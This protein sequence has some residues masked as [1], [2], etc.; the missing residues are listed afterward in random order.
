MHLAGLAS[1]AFIL[2]RLNKKWIIWKSWQLCGGSF[3]GSIAAGLN[4]GPN[5]GEKRN[6]KNP[7]QQ[8][9]SRNSRALK[10]SSG[11]GPCPSSRGAARPRGRWSPPCCP[12]GGSRFA[13]LAAAPPSGDPPGRPRAGAGS[14]GS[15]PRSRPPR[16]RAAA[17]RNR[18]IPRA[19]R[20]AARWARRPGRLHSGSLRPGGVPGSGRCRSFLPPGPRHAHEQVSGKM[21]ARAE[22]RMNTRDDPRS[23][24]RYLITADKASTPGWC[25][26]R[27]TG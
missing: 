17:A 18:R 22:E 20:R 24:R 5:L 23:T 10:Y 27:R 12:V 14:P 6:Q 1:M 25:W 3:N 9:Q 13:R 15:R 4:F 11:I 8:Q 21:C 19:R 16:A 7:P 2:R 26:E